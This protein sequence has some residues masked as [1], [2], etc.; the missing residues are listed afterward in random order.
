MRFCVKVP[1]HYNC[2]NVKSG[3]HYTSV[4]EEVIL[5]PH[6]KISSDNLNFVSV[7]RDTSVGIKVNTRDW[8][9][10]MEVS[11]KCFVT[12]VDHTWLELENHSESLSLWNFTRFGRWWYVTPQYRRRWVPPQIKRW[13]VRPDLNTKWTQFSDDVVVSTTRWRFRSWVLR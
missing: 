11:P 4:L 8:V 13:G 6:R 9:T 3:V 5:R 10:P 1:P 7:S 12:P 2:I